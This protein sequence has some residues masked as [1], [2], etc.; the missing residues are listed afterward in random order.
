MNYYELL[1]LTPQ[2]TPD[3]IKKAYR[4][5]AH[6]FH[7][8]KNQ[9]DKSKEEMFKKISEA[10]EVLSNPEKKRRY[11]ISLNPTQGIRP[12]DVVSNMMND[13][14]GPFARRARDAA[15]AA[16]VNER[17]GEDIEIGIQISFIETI[18]GCIKNIRVP[19]KVNCEKCT[20]S[21]A[22]PGTKVVPCNACNGTGSFVDMFGIGQKK[23]P[24]CRGKRARP[25]DPCASCNGAGSAIG[26][27]D[28]QVNIPAG[29]SGGQVIR[30]AG[31]GESGNPA[32]DLMI[33]VTVI[34][35]PQVRRD[36]LDIVC[37]TEVPLDLM[38]TGGP[39]AYTTP[40]SQHQELM[41]PPNTK[42][43]SALRCKGQGFKELHSS[44]RGDLVVIVHPK[45]PTKMTDK[46]LDL[47]N[48]LWQELKSTNSI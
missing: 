29:I 35:H 14:F 47:W 16:V 39:H 40:Y 4:K 13:I 48:Q 30:L 12:E 43:G 8:D 5:K 23:C 46:A 31:A 24:V 21:G 9:G 11:D 28:I 38:V 19:I 15:R 37:E 3:D 20:G 27:K 41:V 17:P 18:T 32:G 44:R 22:K 2:S 36:N 7:P 26:S 42:S 34:P 33:Q 45:L 25:L 1:D 10:Y 6:E